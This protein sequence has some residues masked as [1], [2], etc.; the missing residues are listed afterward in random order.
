MRA[1]LQGASLRFACLQGAD[2]SKAKLQRANLSDAHLAKVRL[3]RAEFDNTTNFQGV[4]WGEYKVGEELD[5]EFAMAV[6]AYRRLKAWYTQSGYY[7][8]AAKFQYRET[9]SRR[10][11]IKI[12]SKSC[13][14][15]IALQL[16]Y[17]V[18]G[19]GEGWKR[20]LFCWILG[21][22]F[23]S[24]LLYFFLRGVYPYTLTPQAFFS[25]LYYSAVSFT[26][27]GYGPWFNS[28]SVHGWAQGVGAAE[29]FAGI[30]M[31]ALLL[32]TFVRKWTR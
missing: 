29:S 25:S 26:A 31:M 22:I 19:H 14:H 24:T 7:D 2:L 3:Y 28:S 9:E 6:D 4:C 20:L 13:H 23:S 10:K 18:F 12:F 32:V 8:T 16:S 17:L 21:V 11:G 5:N 1:N 30:L 27:L 15:R